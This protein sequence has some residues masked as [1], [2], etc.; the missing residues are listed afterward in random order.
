MNK[1]FPQFESAY[2][3]VT[4]RDE[5]I[6]WAP[7]TPLAI[8]NIKVGDVI[9]FEFLLN[10]TDLRKNLRMTNHTQGN[11]CVIPAGNFHRM[12]AP[13]DWRKHS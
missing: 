7:A 4:W 2:F 9:Q 13:Y 3:K 8:R 6:R 1:V 5:L 11:S 10:A 12:L